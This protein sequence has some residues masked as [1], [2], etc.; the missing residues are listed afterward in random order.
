MNITTLS[1]NII[2]ALL[3]QVFLVIYYMVI[4]PDTQTLYMVVWR[5]TQTFSYILSKMIANW[6]SE[7]S[8]AMNFV[9]PKDG[10]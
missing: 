7:I 8:H 10:L 3:I 9:E 5:D 1:F 4:C 6:K 2:V